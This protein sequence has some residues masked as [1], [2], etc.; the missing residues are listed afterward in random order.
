MRALCPKVCDCV[1]QH[2]R[3][4]AHDDVVSH[5]DVALIRW[6]VMGCEDG[7]RWW[8]PGLWYG[9]N[10][11]IK[12]GSTASEFAADAHGCIM[13]RGLAPHRIQACRRVLRATRERAPLGCVIPTTTSVP[14][15]SG[16]SRRGLETIKRGARPARRPALTAPA[17]DG[18]LSVWVGAKKRASKSNKETNAGSKKESEERRI[19]ALDFES[20][21]QARVIPRIPSAY[22]I[23]SDI[24]ISLN[25][26]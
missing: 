10:A 13:V 12:N 22:S 2:E 1:Q 17:R 8:G 9:Y 11:V 19:I 18:L 5:F 25:H 4:R 20:L 23:N 6:R 24:G 15:G 14:P 16:L 21:I 26:A 7:S 3:A